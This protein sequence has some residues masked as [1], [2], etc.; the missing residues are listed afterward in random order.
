MV[1]YYIDLFLITHY[2]HDLFIYLDILGFEP[3]RYMISAL[4]Y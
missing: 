2:L 3:L 1:Y 4:Y